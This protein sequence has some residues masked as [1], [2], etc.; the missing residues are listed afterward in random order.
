MF[1]IID[2]S[3]HATAAHART[4]SYSTEG[5]VAMAVERALN[6]KFIV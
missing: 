1:E 4:S 2:S 5:N 3:S 6:H